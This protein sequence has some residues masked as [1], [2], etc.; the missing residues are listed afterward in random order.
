MY[1]AGID[2]GGSGGFNDDINEFGA[3]V[4]EDEPEFAFSC[5]QNW[6]AVWSMRMFANGDL[7]C[8]DE[9]GSLLLGRG[10][11]MGLKSSP[12]LLLLEEKEKLI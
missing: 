12:D 1:G 10:I 4:C 7:V 5:R 3:N 9:A 6:I 8:V 11:A 2:V